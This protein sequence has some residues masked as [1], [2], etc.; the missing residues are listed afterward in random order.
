[1]LE[2]GQWAGLAWSCFVLGAIATALAVG[3]L[4]LL[5]HIPSLRLAA[6]LS[7]LFVVEFMGFYSG[8]FALIWKLIE[9]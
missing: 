5:G 9:F 7:V 1:M 2:S 6:I 4:E 3:R 8:L